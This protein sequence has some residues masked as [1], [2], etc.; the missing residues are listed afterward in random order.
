ME[1]KPDKPE[2]VTYD[3]III[4]TGPA[5]LTA[6][7]YA[8][9]YLLKTLVL[10]EIEGGMI[11]ESHKICNFPTQNNISGFELTQ[12][13]ISHVKELGGVIKQESVKE[14]SKSEEIFLI[15]GNKETYKTKKVILA[16]GTKKRKL[17]IPGE[18]E[19]LGKGVSYCATCDSGFFKD[20]VVAVIGGSDAALTSALL[21][22]EYA[23]EVVIISRKDSFFRAEPSWIELVKKNKKI[24]VLFNSNVIKINGKEKVEEMTLDNEKTLAVDGV[25]IEIGSIPNE[26]IP[27]QLKVEMENGY[28]KVNK[29]QETN[30]K[31]FYAAGDITDNPLKQ[32]ITAC[33][34]GAIAAHSAYEE[35]KKEESLKI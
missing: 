13:L 6:A 21:L 15:K 26:E 22:S 31:G 27:Q 32:V 16:I 35:I 34:E 33:G 25:F 28:I 17:D 18:E 23:K 9:R 24:K 7:I 1:S 12:K 29:K 14:I 30:I 20:K 19:F 5:G 4:G 10:G 3:L 8:E 2:E 11:S